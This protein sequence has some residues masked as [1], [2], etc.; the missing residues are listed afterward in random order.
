MA[1]LLDANVFIEAANRYYATDICPGFWDWMEQAARDGRVISTQ[2]VR[3]ELLGREDDLAAWTEQQPASFFLNADAGVLPH[4]ATLATWVR[5]QRYRPEAITEFLDSTD[6]YL[7]ATAMSAGHEIVTHEKPSDGQKRVK[8]PEPCIAHQVEFVNT[9]TMLR[10]L[11][12]R[13]A[14]QRP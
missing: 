7:I 10:R 9:F 11:G 5:Q 1:Y 12:A 2:R 3:D 8:I 13:F 6:Y 14:L 4:L